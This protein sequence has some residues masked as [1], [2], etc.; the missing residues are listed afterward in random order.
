M[1]EVSDIVRISD[2]TARPPDLIARLLQRLQDLF[3]LLHSQYIQVLVLV[4]IP[5]TLLLG[6][7]LSDLTFRR[8]SQTTPGTAVSSPS[9]AVRLAWMVGIL[10]LVANLVSTR[11]HWIVVAAN[12]LALIELVRTFPRELVETPEGVRWCEISGQVSL[13]W[14]EISRFAQKRSLFG[15]E[16]KLCSNDGRGFVINSMIFPGWK[17]MVRRISL[18]LAQRHLVPNAKAE[19]TALDRAHRILA[20]ACLLLIVLGDRFFR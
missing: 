7:L 13:T 19:Q 14:E 1:A 9:I 20:P 10:A 17:Q 12:V 16:C 8:R 2:L 15:I 5:L 3:P 6:V 11:H 4:V 18:N